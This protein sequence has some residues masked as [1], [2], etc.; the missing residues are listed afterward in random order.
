M[1]MVDEKVQQKLIE[2][3]K[4]CCMTTDPEYSRSVIASGELACAPLAAIEEV[5]D[6]STNE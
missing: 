4:D 3:N 1:F 5:S 6:T 2:A